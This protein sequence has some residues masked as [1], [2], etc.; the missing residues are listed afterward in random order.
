[1]QQQFLPSP[2]PRKWCAALCAA[3][4][5]GTAPA[6]E[7]ETASYP[8]LGFSGFGTIGVAHASIDNADFTSSIMKYSGAGRTRRWSPHVDSRLGAQLDLAMDKQW[9]AVVQAVSEQRSDGS[10]KP[11]IEWANIKYQVTPD[12]SL[13]VGRIALPMFLAAD[14]RKIGYAYAWVRPPV[15]MYNAI[16]LSNSDGVDASYRWNVG[17]LKNVTQL[18]YGSTAKPLWDNATLKAHGIAGLSH[19]TSYRDTSIRVSALRAHLSIDLARALFDGYRQ[20]GAAG[21]ALAERFDVDHRRVQ[22]MSVGLNYDPGQWFFMS[23]LGRIKSSSYLGDTY[24]GYASAGYRL[25]DFTPYLSYAAVDPDSAISD[26]GLSPKGMPP[27]QAYIATVL[28]GHLNWL[29]STIAVQSTFSAGARWDV[30]PGLA[31]KLQYDRALPRAGSRGSLVNVHED[32][33][34]GRAVHV[35]SASLDFVF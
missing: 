18:F 34:S 24:T 3:F 10:Y 5:C 15:E 28:N 19:T 9:S 7:G 31:L 20:F 17:S 26:P 16:P 1:M 12:L 21:A 32:F 2:L 25:G 30:G 11:V 35:A 13:R 22:A 23:E 33:R 6:A 27:E 4:A 8:D 29:L 14:Y